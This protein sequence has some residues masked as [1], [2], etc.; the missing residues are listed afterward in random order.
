MYATY[1]YNALNL[2]PFTM[3]QKLID[4]KLDELSF[5]QKRI[6]QLNGELDEIISGK[7][8]TEN[9]IEYI[10]SIEEAL[11]IPERIVKE[12]CL[13]KKIITELGTII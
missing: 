6:N 10:V 8:D 11:Q 3:D 12:E 5:H 4:R 2:K 13:I 7:L 9:K 1:R